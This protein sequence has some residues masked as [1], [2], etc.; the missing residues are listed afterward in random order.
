MQNLDVLEDKKN[1]LL[2]KLVCNIQKLKNRSNMR[3]F[4]VSRLKLLQIYQKQEELDIGLSDGPISEDEQP[5]TSSAKKVVIEEEQE[6]SSSIKEKFSTQ[7]KKK[8]KQKKYSQSKLALQKDLDKEVEFFMNVTVFE[9][10]LN[11][12]KQYVDAEFIDCKELNGQLEN[13]YDT[14]H[15]NVVDLENKAK[16]I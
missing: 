15:K 3:Q 6:K 16:S 9:Q 14:L 7:N 1:T 4:A 12:K 10:I 2:K 11:L 8:N 13:I 5:F